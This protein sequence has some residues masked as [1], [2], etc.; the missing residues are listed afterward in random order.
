[1]KIK[2]KWVKEH[3]ISGKEL[4][5]KGLTVSVNDKPGAGVITYNIVK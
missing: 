5:E 3:L 1:M 4:M 2:S